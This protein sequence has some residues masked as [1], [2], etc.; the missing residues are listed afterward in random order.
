MRKSYSCVKNLL[1][2]PNLFDNSYDQTK[3][4]SLLF[5]KLV[6]SNF[7]SSFVQLR[8]RVSF[9]MPTNFN[10]KKQHCVFRVHIKAKFLKSRMLLTKLTTYF[11][12]SLHRVSE[13]IWKLL[14]SQ[15]LTMNETV[16]IAVTFFCFIK[17]ARTKH[18]SSTLYIKSR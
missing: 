15:W 4:T 2:E 7:T 11:Y 3:S 12:N 9:Q 8:Q 13:S 1:N 14:G 16:W 10:V 18:S 17:D 6:K 5:W